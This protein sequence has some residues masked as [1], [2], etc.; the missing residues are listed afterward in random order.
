MIPTRLPRDVEQLRAAREDPAAFTAFYADHARWVDRWFNIHV[1]DPHVAA[2]LTGET[3]AKALASLS[4]FNGDQP[5]SGTAWLFGIARNLLFRY[6]TQQT[7]ESRARRMLEIRVADI[8][9]DDYERID[10]RLDAEAL[11]ADIRRAVGV[12]PPLLR[13][14]LELR[15][16]DGLSYAEIAVRTGVSEPNARMRFVRALR[17]ARLRLTSKKE[18]L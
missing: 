17:A 8:D 9:V 16:V 15:A 14:S 1:R 13:E 6:R 12:L 10:A 5:G 11:A 7:I 4:R 18:F 2:D 3:F